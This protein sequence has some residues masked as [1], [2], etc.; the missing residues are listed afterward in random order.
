MFNSVLYFLS[1]AL[2]VREVN[3]SPLSAR[4]TNVLL[5]VPG[6]PYLLGTTAVE[7]VDQSR[8][9][10]FNDGNDTSPRALMIS[11]FYPVNT[12]TCHQTYES[13]YVSRTQSEF[14]NTEVVSPDTGIPNITYSAFRTSFCSHD[15]VKHGGLKDIPVILFSPGLGASRKYY[16][17]IAQSVAK[18]GYIVV[19]IDHPYDVDFVEFPDHRIATGYSLI[20]PASDDIAGKA[21]VVRVADVQFVL[22]ELS[23][24]SFATKHLPGLEHG[25]DVKTVGMFGHS[26][27]G[28]TTAQAMLEDS[29]IIGGLN[30][31]GEL[32]GSVVL[33]GLDKPFVNFG[34]S[35]PPDKHDRYNTAFDATWGEIWPYLRNFKAELNLNGS[36]HNTFTDFPF[37][38]KALNI[39]HSDE[40]LSDVLGTIDGMR[41]MEILRKYITAFFDFVLHGISSNLFSTNSTIFPEVSVI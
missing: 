11:I 22:N 18:S 41:D 38:L 12:T 10:T 24:D 37:L 7:L 8:T 13:Q 17:T 28:A 32:Y 21:L 2:L 6:G 16:S 27:G 40:P 14:L 5:S 34:S 39:S 20:A 35:G 23:R 3:S 1:G 4:D 26:I 25:L 9:N 19:T 15:S 33:Q 31:D 36:Q 30:L 29:R